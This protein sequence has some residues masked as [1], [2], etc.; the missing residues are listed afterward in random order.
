MTSK[1]EN[2]ISMIRAVN[3]VLQDN[4]KKWA[5]V[6]RFATAATE[7]NDLL[8]LTG[9]VG[10][11]ANSPI[12]GAT[13]DKYSVE[14]DA[15][16]EGVDIAK[17]ASIYAIDKENMELHDKLRISRS[18]LLQIHEDECLKRLKDV[19][20]QLKPVVADLEDYGIMNADLVHYKTLLEAYESALAKPRTLTVERKTM[21]VT[22]L[23]ELHTKMRKVLYALDS[24]INNFRQTPLPA[25][26]KNA[27]LVMD[28]GSRES[29]ATK[30]KRE[31]EE[32]KKKE[33]EDKK[34]EE[35]KGGEEPPV[36]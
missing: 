35:E 15:I 33:E 9:T 2:F 25:E 22:L 3:K 12:T 5:N 30:K 27:R 13:K 34:K 28:L 29:E 8:S 7:L 18:M 26:Y 21:N 20:E 19:Y 10:T 1:Q 4:Q 14:E 17:R 24:L 36:V 32:K 23:P 11:K 16:E 6:K 31:D